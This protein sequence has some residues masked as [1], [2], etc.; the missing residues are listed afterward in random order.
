MVTASGSGDR[1]AGLS[2]TRCRERSFPV[3]AGVRVR[4]GLRPI[5]MAAVLVRQGRLVC[6]L[7][8]TGR[9]VVVSQFFLTAAS[10]LLPLM[11]VGSG[12]DPT[13]WQQVGVVRG[14]LLCPRGCDL[15]HRLRVGHRRARDSN[16]VAPGW[17]DPDRRRHAVRSP[18]PRRPSARRRRRC[19]RPPPLH[20]QSPRR[21]TRG[22]RGR[23][24]K[25]VQS[26][27]R[28]L[29]RRGFLVGAQQLTTI[30]CQDRSGDAD[31]RGCVLVR[32]QENGDFLDVN[33]AAFPSS[34]TAHTAFGGLKKG[35]L[36]A[37]SGAAV[38]AMRRSA[39][40][41]Y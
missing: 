23:L 15:G 40:D 28:R 22:G 39:T 35:W 13:V 41:R 30:N 6:R 32:G 36:R 11:C 7:P 27:G 19:R 20:R 31:Y 34:T 18:R 21:L 1:G 26:E 14:G 24:E 5:P 16:R 38:V 10:A 9:A 8:P 29:G 37:G 33:A 17:G 25:R 4:A 3:A 2:R 12:R